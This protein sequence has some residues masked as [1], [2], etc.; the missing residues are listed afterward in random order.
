MGVVKHCALACREALSL[1]EG[2]DLAVACR[3]ARG[4]MAVDCVRIIAKAHTLGPLTS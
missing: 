4:S 2:I 1:L 3:R